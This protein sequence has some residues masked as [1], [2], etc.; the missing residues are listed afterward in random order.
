MYIYSPRKK[1]EKFNKTAEAIVD[2]INKHALL[3]LFSSWKMLLWKLIVFSPASNMAIIRIKLWSEGN[4]SKGYSSL[5][6]QF[7]V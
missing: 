7:E 4:L 6:C 5:I 2:T 3:I 1:R